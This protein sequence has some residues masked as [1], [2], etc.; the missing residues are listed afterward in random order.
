MKK[1]V[2]SIKST[3]NA[4]DEITER[5]KKA[6]LKK[7]KVNPYYEISFTEMKHFKRFIANI[8]ILT[9]IYL[10]KPKSIYDLANIMQKDVGNINKLLNFFEQLGAI[11]LQEKK[12][13][14]R[15]VK[16]P[17]VRYQKIEFDLAA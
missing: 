1:L 11:E 17:V 15:I 4:L 6:Q 8:D 3:S 13:S 12:V 7:G 14:G 2:I 5:L 9:S 16:K 10:L